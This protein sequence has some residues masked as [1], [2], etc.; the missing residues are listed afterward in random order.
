MMPGPARQE[1]ANTVGVPVRGTKGRTD[2]DS[3]GRQWIWDEEKT[4]AKGN[5]FKKENYT[6]Y[7]EGEGYEIFYPEKKE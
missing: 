5:P 4:A 2:I 1:L 6:Y 7:P 3:D